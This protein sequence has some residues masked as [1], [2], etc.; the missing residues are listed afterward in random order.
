MHIHLVLHM[1]LR[2]SQSDVFYWEKRNFDHHFV[3][4][5][6]TPNRLY[7]VPYF[8]SMK[9][10]FQESRALPTISFSIVVHTFVVLSLRDNQQTEHTHQHRRAFVEERRCEDTHAHTPRVWRDI[11]ARL[12]RLPTPICAQLM[13][14]WSGPI[15]FNITN[16]IYATGTNNGWRGGNSLPVPGRIL[17]PI[18]AAW[19]S[20]GTTE[21][22]LPYRLR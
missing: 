12:R 14:F 17:S 21:D 10:L 2:L 16:G 6:I 22:L 3:S 20:N 1:L 5:S 11:D 4:E 8:S 7:F 18:R 19:R 13:L 15:A 9:K